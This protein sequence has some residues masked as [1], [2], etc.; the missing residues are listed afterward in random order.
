MCDPRDLGVHSDPA[1]PLAD[2]GPAVVLY[3]HIPAGI[4][5]SQRLYELHAE[6]LGRAEELISRCEC[7][8]GC[9]SCVGPSGE[10]G[11]GGKAE[12]LALLNNFTSK[13]RPK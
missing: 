5:F 12:A 3:D 8:D 11:M 2:G 10:N 1:S 7:V 6:L 4:G 9:P 13:I